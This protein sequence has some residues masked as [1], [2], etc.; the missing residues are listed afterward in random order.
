MRAVLGIIVG[1]V[2][3][4]F[5]VFAIGMVGEMLFPI[6][7]TVDRTSIESIAAVLPN[8]PAGAKAALLLSWFGGALAGAY[9]AKRIVG[10]AWAA[11]TIAGVTAV[12]VILNVMI[13]PMPGWLQVAAVA[14]PLIG[15]LLGNHLVADAPPAAPPA[16][17]S[18]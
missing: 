10:R 3:A 14:A 11:W 17:A 6:T 8:L 18:A 4:L 7:A 9:A 1:I 15:G 13:L 2:V 12:I 5:F 16:D